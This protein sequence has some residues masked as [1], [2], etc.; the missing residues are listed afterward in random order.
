MARLRAASAFSS[1][2]YIRK[3]LPQPKARMETLAPV[4]PRVRWG[5]PDEAL[6]AATLLRM[7]SVTAA[8]P[9]PSRSRKPRRERSRL[10]SASSQIPVA[11]GFSPAVSVHRL[12][13]FPRFR[14]QEL[15]PQKRFPCFLL[16]AF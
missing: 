15:N 2:S 7:G 14:E 12:H 4:R 3:R 13:R 8:E 11:L 6:P 16:L 5:R 9:K 10:I 1:S